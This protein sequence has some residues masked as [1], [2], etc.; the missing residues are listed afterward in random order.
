MTAVPVGPNNDKERIHD[1]IIEENI[2]TTEKN[3][4]KMEQG[5]PK[6]ASPMTSS[7]LKGSTGKQPSLGDINGPSGSEGE[8]KKLVLENTENFMASNN[9]HYKV[10]GIGEMCDSYDKLIEMLWLYEQTREKIKPFC[11]EYEMLS[12]FTFMQKVKQI[13]SIFK[14]QIN[15][16]TNK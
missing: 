3:Q 8:M 13:I 12:H 6:T 14:Q 11:G 4:F 9:Y 1:L 15:S 2:K 5:G 16:C 10:K 7:P